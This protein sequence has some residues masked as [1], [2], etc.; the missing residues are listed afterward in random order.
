[1]TTEYMREFAVLAEKLNYI[2]A[3]QALGTTQASLSR[4][5]MAMEKELGFRL[6]ERNTRNAEL[7]LS[8]LRF[9]YYAQ[10][11]VRILD[12]CRAELT[13]DAAYK[14][15][16]EKMK[17]EHIREFIKAAGSDELQQS[18]AALGI[19]PSVLT[20]HMSSLAS[21]IGASLFM[22]TRKTELSRFGKIFLPYAKQLARLQDEYAAD[23]AGDALAPS[24]R[25]MIGI[26]P[27]Q[28]KDRARQIL[29]GFAAQYPSLQLDL[30]YADEAEICGKLQAGEFDIAVREHG[31]VIG[32][33][34]ISFP[35]CRYRLMAIF[36]KTHPLAG[37]S[38]I[39]LQQLRYIKTVMD[40]KSIAAGETV[41]RKCRSLGFEPDISYYETYEAFEK[42]KLGECI[43]LQP[44]SP[45]LIGSGSAFTSVPVS[46]EISSEL[47]L[48][49]RREALDAPG[50]AFMKY[51]EENR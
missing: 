24:G 33:G 36:P 31:N 38:D 22:R 7:T 11:T 49:L 42:I 1:M 30:I 26:S 27:I 46:P 29:D 15:I 4:H 18:A 3:A 14:N 13:G 6:L 37:T 32:E 51:A 20:K 34:L 12:S 35:F 28:N 9:L 17:F 47:D 16:C 2:A 5:I 39:E 48:V 23:F 10:E 45:G 41:I 50:W 25:L 43:L 40:S 8:G 21:D 44:I 19:S